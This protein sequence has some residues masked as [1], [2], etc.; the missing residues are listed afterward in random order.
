MT[1][2]AELTELQQLDAAVRLFSELWGS[3]DAA[4][5]VTVALLRALQLS[6][7]YV[8]GAFC[9]DH[10]VG[11]CVGW[12]TPRPGE[13]H[14]H[15]TGVDP[16]QRRRGAALALKLHQR[17][18]ALDQGFDCIT[19]TFDPLVRR[20]AV[21]NLSRLAVSVDS[22]AENLYGAMGDLLNGMQESDRLLVRWVLDGPS[23]QNAARRV[24][25]VVRG[26]H[27]VRLAVTGDGCPNHRPS[28]PASTFAVEVHPD[29]EALRHSKPELA[30][31]WRL[32]VRAVLGGAL[33]Q[34][35]TVLG[36][37]DEGR[38]IVASADRAQ[39]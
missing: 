19:W 38:Y 17:R 5:P 18:W 11:A 32:A 20:N 39:R 14:S 21:F 30:Q 29:I 28:S 1:E 22:Y 37:D 13:L 34:G 15:I 2:I 36:L 23:A 9:D 6:G 25:A 16:T 35:A 31:Q 24:P 3:P 10:L 27:P 7:N 26:T 33:A 8:F 12:A 4:P